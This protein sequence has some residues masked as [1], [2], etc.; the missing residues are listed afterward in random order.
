MS[1][2]DTLDISA[3]ALK[4][5]KKRKYLWERPNQPPETPKEMFWRVADSVSKAE[6]FWNAAEQDL[7]RQKFFELQ[8]SGRF[9]PNTPTLLNAG[10]ERGQLA[11]CFVLPIGDSMESIM[12][13]IKAQALV[14]KSG[15]G[16]GFSF[17]SIRERGALI[18]TTQMKA[19]GP[20]SVIKLMN[21][22]MTEFIIQGGARDGANMAALPVDHNDI[23]EFITFKK[24]D[25]SC[26]SFNVSATATDLFM[27]AVLEDGVIALRSRPSME[28]IRE[29]PARQIFDLICE[30]AWMTGDPGLLFIDTANKFNPTPH[31]GR[32]EAT[33]PCGEQWLLPDEACTLGHLNLSRYY[34]QANGTDWRANFN[35]AQF[36]SDIYWG[37]R[38]LDDVIEVNYYPLSQ[39]EQMHRFTNR[40]IGLGIMGLADLF[41]KL[42]VPYGSMESFEVSDEIGTFYQHHADH[43]S[44][45]LGLDRG[46]FPAFGRSALASRFKAMRNACRTTVAPTGTTAI[47]AGCSC[48]IEPLFALLLRRQQAGMEMQEIHPLFEGYL[49]ALSTAERRRVIDY[50]LEHNSIK[51]CN[52]L[53][54]AT[55]RLFA[56]AND[57]SPEQHIKMQ[58][59]WQR[60]VDNSISKTINMPHSTTVE[61]VKRAYL[62]A[63]SSGCKGI[64]IYRDGSRDSQPLSTAT[65]HKSVESSLCRECN[66]PLEIAGGCE[67][68]HNC[69]WSACSTT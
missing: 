27:Q 56:Q 2:G 46:S 6:C 52:L 8:S 22:I 55:T 49:N 23:F 26:K 25:G 43:A 45:R 34:I 63:W 69:G 48:G 38:F 66:F 47:I 4:I 31:L 30:Y 29:V 62:L 12:D 61:D 32:L 7:A 24:V 33:N 68:C 58:A 60:H 41:I 59:V 21:Y 19:A 44:S 35:W 9:I 13:S 67:T 5:L 14:Q 57:I 54:P 64:T 1:D 36:Q 39:V 3:N 18:S 50:Y 20:I 42:Q 37:V 51:G 15:G 17:G 10:R 11:A 40:K 28:I 53:T 65:V 16:T